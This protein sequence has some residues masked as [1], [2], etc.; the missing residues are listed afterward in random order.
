MMEQLSQQKL[1]QQKL[2]Q[3]L[4]RHPWQG[5][6]ISTGGKVIIVMIAIIIL[7]ACLSYLLSTGKECKSDKK[8]YIEC[9]KEKEMSFF[10]N[11]NK[12]YSENYHVYFKDALIKA[13]GGLIIGF[14]LVTIIY[15]LL[16][17]SAIAA[18]TYLGSRKYIWRA[19]T[20]MLVT[21]G[22]GM[23]SIGIILASRGGIDNVLSKWKMVVGVGILLGTFNLALE[24]SGYNRY[25]SKSEIEKGIGPYAEI[26]GIID[27][28]VDPDQL[29]QV[30]E[31]GDPFI[32]SLAYVST[33]MVGLILLYLI[34]IMF[35][36]TY[37]GYKDP[38]NS[39]LNATIFGHSVAKGAS[40]SEMYGLYIIELI[41]I[42][43]LLNTVPPLLSPIIRGHNYT[44]KYYIV[45]G[46]IFVIAIVLQIMLQFNGFLIA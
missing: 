39:I 6:G 1:Q 46:L 9:L 26:N 32:N 3:Q 8:E 22:V 16:Y 31:G 24:S 20:D 44:W 36:S 42:G 13:K 10:E 11:M 38:A 18:R 27:G 25:L 45:A 12:D 2:Q 7:I 43:G 29:R 23:L 30:E 17:G 28:T 5:P 40:P 33:I 35:I 4:Q 21:G 14:V 37:Y 41:S 15:Q 19:I 34:L